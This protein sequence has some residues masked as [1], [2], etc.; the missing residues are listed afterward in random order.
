M[1][2]MIRYGRYMKQA[3]EKDI[4]TVFTFTQVSA[5]MERSFGHPLLK[6]ATYTWPGYLPSPYLTSLLRREV[7][8]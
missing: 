4:F 7:V 2:V 3:L 6:S 8:L 1:F 5:Y